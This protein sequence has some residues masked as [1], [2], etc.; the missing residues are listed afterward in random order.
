MAKKKAIDWKAR[1]DAITSRY[2]ITKA[3][4]AAR[5]G[6]TPAAVTDWTSGRNT[7]PRCVQKLMKMM[8]AGNDLKEIEG[9]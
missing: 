7:P 9:I 1:I 8:E 4:F 2:G 6:V 5:V 3:K